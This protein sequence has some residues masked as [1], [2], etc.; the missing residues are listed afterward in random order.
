MEHTCPVGSTGSEA[1]RPKSL[2]RSNFSL[3]VRQPPL[4]VHQETSQIILVAAH[5]L[6]LS[7]KHQIQVNFVALHRLAHLVAREDLVRLRCWI[8]R[9]EAQHG[10][11]VVRIVVLIDEE[12]C[13][14]GL[15]G[16]ELSLL[17]NVP[18]AA[19]SLQVIRIL[20]VQPQVLVKCDS[21]LLEES[22]FPVIVS[23]ELFLLM[24]I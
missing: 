20:R 22:L 4:L 11:D 8:V 9:V 7:I 15:E 5:A 10:S 1:L 16:F 18:V 3:H 12:V 24:L 23:S 21:S 6:H 17:V 19:L 2:A 14:L 13:P